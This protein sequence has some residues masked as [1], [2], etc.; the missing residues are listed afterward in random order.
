MADLVRRHGFALGARRFVAGETLE[1]GLRVVADLERRGFLVTLDILGEAVGD[2]AAA[3]Q[4]HAAYVAA[5]SRLGEAGLASH[6][7]VKPT[8]L[9]LEVDEGLCRDQVLDLALRAE[10]QG[11]FVR[12]DM[13]DSRY[14]EGTLR[15]FEAV[16]RETPAVGVVLQAYLYRTEADLARLHRFAADLPGG[17]PPAPGRAAPS[18]PSPGGSA[19]PAGHGLLNVRFCKGAY[20]EPPDRAF[21]RKADVDAN[22]ARLV[23]RHLEAGHFAAIATHDERLLAGLVA[24]T[25]EAGIPPARWEIQML[26]GVRRDL[27]ERLRESGHP[28]RLYV[29][30][31]REWYRYFLRRL[32]ERPANLGFVLRQLLAEGFPARRRRSPGPGPSTG[33][34]PP[35]GPGR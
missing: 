2:A 9:G 22:F 8:Q 35:G 23:R 5:L 34:T 30:C 25:R 11:T 33:A 29:P 21:P 12:L 6:V 20:S 17:G 1:E 28:V 24:W 16:R 15:L 10:R 3:R 4:A 18:A 14:T 13:E 27:Q 26:Y 19:A 32:A 31:G 7:S